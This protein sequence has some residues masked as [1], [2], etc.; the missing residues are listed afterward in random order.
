MVLLGLLLVLR[1]VLVQSRKRRGALSD[2]PVG[3][4]CVCS[5]NPT[6]FS[7][8][9]FWGPAHLDKRASQMTDNRKAL[10]NSCWL[11][12]DGMKIKKPNANDYF[13]GTEPNEFV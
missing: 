8:K 2:G 13:K 9:D 5:R 7:T 10:G 4:A 6:P 1:E 3:N 12:D 11:T